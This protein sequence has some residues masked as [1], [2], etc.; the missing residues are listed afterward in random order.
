MKEVLVSIIMPTYQAEKTIKKSI[1]SVIG[2]TFLNWELIIVDDAS[3]DNTFNIIQKYEKMDARIAGI[4]LEYNQG[5]S[6]ARNTGLKCAKGKYVTFLDADD[7]IDKNEIK[8]AFEYAEKESAYIV[9]WGIV[10]EK[11]KGS[12]KVG[13]AELLPKSGK[14][15]EKRE[16]AENIVLL[17]KQKVFSYVW[18]KLYLRKILSGI[19]FDEK[20][21]NE[22]FLFNLKV[23]PECKSLVILDDALYHYVQNSH[24]TLSTGYKLNYFEIMKDRFVKLYKFAIDYG[25]EN[26]VINDLYNV[27]NKI[28]VSTIMRYWFPDNKDSILKKIKKITDVLNDKAVLIS[29]R[30]AIPL[31]Y[32]DKIYKIVLC[33]PVKIVVIFCS[34]I[35]YE[36]YQN[37]PTFIYKYK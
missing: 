37:F 14:F 32:R 31:D 24:I 5:P 30:K 35:L 9:V 16:I 1:E 34:W 21:L 7:W 22:D 36:I 3:K 18:N 11:Y 17:D 27:Q 28:W 2:Q 26:T 33:F 8:K 20:R 25:V 12:V 4:Q 6:V 15:S 19:W 29:S 23:F 10:Q 13:Q